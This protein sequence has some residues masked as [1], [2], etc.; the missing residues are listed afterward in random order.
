MILLDDFPRHQ[1]R[2]IPRRPII[3]RSSALAGAIR[4]RDAPGWRLGAVPRRPCGDLCISVELLRAQG[5][6]RTA[7]RRAHAAVARDDLSPGRRRARQHLYEVSPGAVRPVS[8][9]RRSGDSTRDGLPARRR[10]FH[11]LRHVQLVANDLRAAVDPLRAEA[12]GSAC[13]SGAASTSCSCRGIPRGGRPRQAVDGAFD[14]A[15]GRSRSTARASHGRRSSS[16][17]IVCS[18]RYERLPGAG[19]CDAWAIERAAPG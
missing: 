18:K 10:T 16:A 19:R 14:D 8:V 12:A 13:R 5:R 2:D 4:E 7:R 9:E 6:R 11:G 15:P 17:S 1:R 3:C